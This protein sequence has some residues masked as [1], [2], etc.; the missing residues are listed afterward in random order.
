MVS[1]ASLASMPLF[2]LAQGR[3]GA[4]SVVNTQNTIQGII[5]KA[6]EILGVVLPFLVALAVVI[7]V[8]GVVMYVVSSDEEAKSAGRNRMIWGIVGLAVIVS[9]WGLV[10]ILTNTFDLNTNQGVTLP[11]LPY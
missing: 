1:A 9:L 7:F 10:R 11:V 5:C 2:A 3:G 6:G 8:W 4:C